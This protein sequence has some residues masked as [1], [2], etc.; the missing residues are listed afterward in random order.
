MMAIAG[1]LEMFV[2]QIRS[3]VANLGAA[4]TYQPHHLR[5]PEVQAAIDRAQ[6]IYISGYFLTA[7]LDTILEVSRLAKAAGKIICM[8]L[9]APFICK[10]FITQ[11]CQVLP[12][13]DFLFG[14]ESEALALSD[15]FSWNLQEI[16]QI[17]T[18]MSQELIGC[19]EGLVV[20]TQGSQPTIVSQKDAPLQC[21]PVQSIPTDQIVDTNGAGDAFVGGYLSEYLKGGNL[22]TCVE[23]GHYAAS[24]IIRR[25]GVVFDKNLESSPGDN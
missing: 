11:L 19:S 9:S 24:Y 2:L 23:K 4:N 1:I 15:A 10:F 7:S 25:S 16:D 21:F 3:L 5:L 17:A 18:K 6:V 12:F 14:N 8:N 20:I 22:A 13:V